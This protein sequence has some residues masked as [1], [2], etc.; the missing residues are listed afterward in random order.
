VTRGN[1]RD[2]AGRG[3]AGHCRVTISPAPLSSLSPASVCTCRLARRP[4]TARP[5]RGGAGRARRA[6]AAGGRGGCFVLLFH[7]SITAGSVMESAPRCARRMR[8]ARAARRR[9]RTARSGPR[10]A[11]AMRRRRCARERRSRRP[12]TSPRC[13]QAA[14]RRCRQ[15]S[16]VSLSLGTLREGRRGERGWRAPAQEFSVWGEH[17]PEN[18]AH[19]ALSVVP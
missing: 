16:Q 13:C 18:V 11:A 14:P 1:S 5:H 6:G 7:D 17:S 4:L 2:G 9:G 19:P 12:I 8:R 3:G 15:R 10:P